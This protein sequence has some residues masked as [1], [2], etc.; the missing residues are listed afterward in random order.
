[1]ED[2]ALDSE[3]F[4]HRVLFNKLPGFPLVF[5]HGYAFTSEV[6]VSL[7]VLRL[8]EEHAVPFVAMDMPYGMKS[9]CTPKTRDA[10]AN[11]NLIATTVRNIFG[12]V[13]PVLVGASLGGYIALHYSIQNPVQGL[14]LIAP[15]G[16]HEFR[17][18][19][20]LKMCVRVIYGS[21]DRVVPLGEMREFI[22]S[23][24]N[25]K[26]GVY[27]GANHPA[28][29]GNADRFKEDLLTTYRL[30]SEESQNE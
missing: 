22:R 5:L 29:L 15:V 20:R 17:G 28:Y 12:G 27:D 6:W 24:P 2:L 14:L 25:A 18:H 9:A 10:M 13:K 23:L 11:I 8:L 30:C 4:R 26:L 16:T 21:R 19:P 7:N 3:A 1:M